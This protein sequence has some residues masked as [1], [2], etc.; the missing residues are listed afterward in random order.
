MTTKVQRR[1]EKWKA[2]I[3]ERRKNV[4]LESIKKLQIEDLQRTFHGHFTL[5]G[6]IHEYKGYFAWHNSFSKDLK[7]RKGAYNSE[8]LMPKDEDFDLANQ[9]SEQEPDSL[10]AWRK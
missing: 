3:S 8:I 9:E 7:A 4:Q 5:S 2:D 10:L 1:R 6:R